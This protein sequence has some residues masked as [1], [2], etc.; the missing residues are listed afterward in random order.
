MLRGQLWKNINVNGKSNPLIA[1]CEF[2]LNIKQSNISTSCKMLANKAVLSKPSVGLTFIYFLS[3][4]SLQ[5][6]CNII[7]RSQKR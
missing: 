2:N 6:T 7:D 4:T 5:N 3:P 1:M